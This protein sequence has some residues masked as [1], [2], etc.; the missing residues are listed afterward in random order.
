MFIEFFSSLIFSR[1][2]SKARLRVASEEEIKAIQDA[3]LNK[4]EDVLVKY[5]D[6]PITYKMFKRLDPKVLS[7]NEKWLND[8]VVSLYMEMLQ[9]RDE[10]LCSADGDR[11]RSIFFT[12]L[13]FGLFR[14]RGYKYEDLIR[15]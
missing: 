15:Y 3:F 13:F 1:Y 4:S 5:F 14:D 12:P 9:Q 6:I 8:E 11:K 2:C 10:N 7:D